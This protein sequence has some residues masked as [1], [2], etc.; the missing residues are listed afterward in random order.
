M[1]VYSFSHTRVI[2][3]FPLLAKYTC[4]K[5]EQ[6]V[7]KQLRIFHILIGKFDVKNFSSN[8]AMLV[9]PEQKI[10][11]EIINLINHSYCQQCEV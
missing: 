1:L 11:Q 7:A 6:V 8:L 2:S 5:D 3:T 10:N 9:L 4:Q